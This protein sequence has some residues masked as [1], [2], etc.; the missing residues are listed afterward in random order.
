MIP[1]M[2][3]QIFIEKKLH[4]NIKFCNIKNLHML[5]IFYSSFQMSDKLLSLHHFDN[6]QNYMRR[7]LQCQLD[8]VHSL[9][10]WCNLPHHLPGLKVH[11]LLDKYNNDKIFS[12]KE[13]LITGEK[14]VNVMLNIDWVWLENPQW[15][16]NRITYLCSSGLNVKY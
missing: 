5:E 16:L 14:I 1:I 13:Y 6:N 2:I 11:I 4:I 15:L 9:L 8:T 12:H 3:I 7:K 10:V